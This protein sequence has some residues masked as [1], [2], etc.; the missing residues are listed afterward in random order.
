MQ[1]ARFDFVRGQE[2]GRPGAALVFDREPAAC[3]LLPR[4]FHALSPLLLFG[5]LADVWTRLSQQN[6]CG[7]PCGGL[8][9]LLR[10]FE[11]SNPEG[12]E[13]RFMGVLERF[14]GVWLA[15][16]VLRFQCCLAG[17][18]QRPGAQTT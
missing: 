9:G 4:A 1:P 15:L 11:V 6:A 14:R 17:R 2:N 10:R 3:G 18:S 7:W 8:Y 12:L 13:S 5:S 16:S